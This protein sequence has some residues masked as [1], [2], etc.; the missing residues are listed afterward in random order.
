MLSLSGSSPADAS[1][2]GEGALP[3]RPHLCGVERLIL[4]CAFSVSALLLLLSLGQPALHVD[5]LWFFRR[6]ISLAAGLKD[7]IE[8][9]Q[10]ALGWAILLL[11]VGLPLVKIVFGLIISAL[12]PPPGAALRRLTG[13]FGYLGKWSLADVLVLAVVV[14]IVDGQVLSA[15]S[16]GA[17]A[18]LFAAAIFLSTAAT[19]WLHL[20]VWRSPGQR[21]GRAKV[22]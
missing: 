18:Y 3:P 19:A 1:A 21:A 14:M 13:L 11:S 17:G 12:A 16:L 22:T 10:A 7:L 8:G 4:F 20:A 6:D 9:G 2:R 5:R 15:A